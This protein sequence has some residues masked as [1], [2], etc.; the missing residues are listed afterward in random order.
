MFN[1]IAKKE[2]KW[3]SHK[4]FVKAQSVKRAKLRIG[5]D[6]WCHVA[7]QQCLNMLHQQIAE[8]NFIHET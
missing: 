2:M 8:W 3:S 5:V 6:D 4:Q 1:G 7:V